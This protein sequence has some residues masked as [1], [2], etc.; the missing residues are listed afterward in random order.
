LIPTEERNRADEE[1]IAKATMTNE[2]IQQLKKLGIDVRRSGWQQKQQQ[3]N[4]LQNDSNLTLMIVDQ[5][6]SLTVELNDD[7]KET[8]EEDAIGLA[9]Y[10]NI[11]S[12]TF[13]HISI[14]ENLWMQTEVE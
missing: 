10:S 9:T 4:I 6:L 1:G 12:T 2:T 11:D 14:F 8:F 13:A 3:Q 7:A 5:S